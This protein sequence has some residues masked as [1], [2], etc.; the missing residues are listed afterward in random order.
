MTK[1]IGSM[2]QEELN[3]FLHYLEELLEEEEKPK[4]KSKGERKGSVKP[5]LP[6]PFVHPNSSDS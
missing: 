4:H 3:R 2:T 5:E 1:G 6:P